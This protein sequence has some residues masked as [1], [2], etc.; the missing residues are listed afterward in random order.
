MSS[1][2]PTITPPPLESCLVRSNDYS[3]VYDVSDTG[4]I[5]TGQYRGIIKSITAS[6]KQADVTIVSPDG[7]DSHT[8]HIDTDIPFY[9]ALHSKK[10]ILSD[11]TPGQFIGIG[12]NCNKSKGN[13]FSIINMGIQ[14]K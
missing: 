7:K 2:I 5:I 11:F 10:I 6:G 14:E 13:Q 4:K 8:F 1:A 12:F 9:D 3:L